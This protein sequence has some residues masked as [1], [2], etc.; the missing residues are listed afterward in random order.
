MAKYYYY[1]CQ[2]STSKY[3]LTFVST[4]IYL[5]CCHRN[6]SYFLRFVMYSIIQ[7][8]KHI[9]HCCHCHRREDSV[10]CDET[11]TEEFGK[12]NSCCLDVTLF[13]LGSFWFI[14]P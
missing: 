11:I 7:K 3:I 10:H 2:E 13:L 12:R 6:F 5:R 1:C 8:E 4:N 14:K 9:L